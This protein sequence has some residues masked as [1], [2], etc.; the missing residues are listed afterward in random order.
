MYM[1]KWASRLTLEIAEV[2][3]ERVQDISEADCRAEGVKLLKTKCDGECG[4][5]PCGIKRQP[6]ANLWDSINAGRN[7]GAYAWERNPWVWVLTFK[8]ASSA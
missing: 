5:T 8:I 6:F 3:V 7:D 2:R 1:P 4:M